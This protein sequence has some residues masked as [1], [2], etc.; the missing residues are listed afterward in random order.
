ME[1]YSEMKGGKKISF[2]KDMTLFI[3][4][5]LNGQKNCV[6]GKPAKACTLLNLQIIIPNRHQDNSENREGAGRKG[7]RIGDMITAAESFLNF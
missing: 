5:F 1:L 7:R 2:N 3:F 6:K 4:F